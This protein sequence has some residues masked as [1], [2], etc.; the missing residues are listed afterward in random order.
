MV[1]VLAKMYQVAIVQDSKPRDYPPRLVFEAHCAHAHWHTQIPRYLFMTAVWG[2]YYY[3]YCIV[4]NPFCS[5]QQN[6]ATDKGTIKNLTATYLFKLRADKKLKNIKTGPVSNWTF[7]HK[8]RGLSVKFY[9]ITWIYQIIMI[10]A[11]IKNI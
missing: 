6:I 1:T 8:I 9:Y 5:F 11:A 3:I 2:L 4:I 10:L 7:T